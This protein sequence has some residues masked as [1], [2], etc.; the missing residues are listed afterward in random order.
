MENDTA[1]A[2][3]SL[4]MYAFEV[5]SLYVRRLA[6]LRLYAWQTAW[7]DHVEVA[8]GV[9]DPQSLGD[10]RSGARPGSD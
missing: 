7:R 9:P 4:R 10:F 5:F 6:I 1:S 3:L 8:R 2:W